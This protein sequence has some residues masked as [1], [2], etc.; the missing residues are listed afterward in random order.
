[1]LNADTTVL[2]GFM[3]SKGFGIFVGVNVSEPSES[4]LPSSGPT[5]NQV[6]FHEAAVRLEFLSDLPGEGI[7]SVRNQLFLSIKSSASG[8]QLI[9]LVFAS[10]EQV[11]QEVVRALAGRVAAGAQA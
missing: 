10:I 2:I 5:R 8:Q 11:H 3:D 6:L 1:M 4:A 7:S 9:D